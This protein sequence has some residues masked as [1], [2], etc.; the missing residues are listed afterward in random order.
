MKLRFN[1]EL[2][3]VNFGEFLWIIMVWPN[4]SQSFQS[5]SN[6]T[7]WNAILS[8]LL[9]AI[10]CHDLMMEVDKCCNRDFFC[11]NRILMSSNA[12]IFYNSFG[13]PLAADQLSNAKH[14]GLLSISGFI[15]IYK[16]ENKC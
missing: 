7:S 15:K 12:I 5:F 14:F 2:D 9:L 4:E 13:S 16:V 11:A 8:L 3:S 1:K 6:K 10:W